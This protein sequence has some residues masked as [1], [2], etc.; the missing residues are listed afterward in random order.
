MCNVQHSRTRALSA[1]SP[2]KADIQHI[3]CDL[4]GGVTVTL[5]ARLGEAVMTISELTALRAGSV[6]TLET[7]LADQ[8]EL[9]LDGTLV[10]RGE[11]V[12]VGDMFGIRIAELAPEK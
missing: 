12:A 5:E 10:A 2:V 8:A 11:I 3:D 1:S 4:I 9:F 6:V 7:G